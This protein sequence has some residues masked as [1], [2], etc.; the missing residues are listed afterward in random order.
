MCGISGIIS[1][2]KNDVTTS[3]LKAMTDVLAHRGP[4]G[5][6]QWISADSTVGFGH[7]RLTIIDLSNAGKQPMHFQNRYTIVFN[8]A[9]YNYVELREI[10]I[11]KGYVFN[12]QSDT[13]VIMAMYDWK[14]EECLHYFDG[15][16]AFVLHDAAENILF[17][18]RDRFGEKP[19]YYHHKPGKFFVF[20]SE[21][22]ALWAAGIKKEINNRLLYN[23][24]A[25]NYIQNDNDLSE[26]FFQ[27]IRNL[28]PAHYLQLSTSTLE[29]SE[30]KYWD[31][32][33]RKISSDITIDEAKERFRQLFYKSVN[34]R[35]RCDV[36]VGSSLS[37]GIDSST[38][39]AVIN[40]INKSK[41]LCTFSAI[42]PGFEKDE[43]RFIQK[44]LEKIK[45]EAHYTSPDGDTL[46]KNTDECFYYQE[47]PFGSASVIAQY[48]VMKLAK[49]HNVT[50]L[51][52]GQGADEALAGYHHFYDTYF[53]ELKT[54]DRKIY[55]LEKAAYNSMFKGNKINPLPEKDLRYYAGRWGWPGKDRLK[56]IR[57]RINQVINPYFNPDFYYAYKNEQFHSPM[58]ATS[59]NQAL[60][61]SIKFGLPQL[62]RFADRN[63]M[64]NGREIRLPFLF[65]ELVELIFTL[66]P[67][68]KIHNGWTKYI[69][70][71][72]F[73]ELLPTSIT[74]R[75]DKIGYEPPQ[76]QWMENK[77]LKDK[78][79]NTREQLVK[80]R[81]LNSRV[82]KKP[83]DGSEANI[84]KKNGWNQLMISCLLSDKM[85][86]HPN[87][88][89]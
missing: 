81:I 38:I 46:L 40:D 33:H 57:E 70:R 89:K 11:N 27:H 39:V 24:M 14:K 26:T 76:R 73:E 17:I 16:F 48:G 82:L 49:Q 2:D 3:R 6:G 83:I 54:R 78:I 51:L 53:T 13:E 23:Y 29:C 20:A 42:F 5:D 60:Y 44:L 21:M 9:I 47:E 35:L 84:G 52:D 41:K 58:P 28:P 77:T 12:S 56:K 30:K 43:S 74:W 71:I 69:E 86:F 63:S 45:V 19:L 34:R 37:G 80:D 72:S 7:R 66:P 31:I 61:N 22:K 36:S 87:Q 25:F 18:A 65:H 50:V 8:G 4:D 62:L 68:F 55:K 1:V 88:A 32:D 59:L 67:A 85:N 75:K 79:L 15:M 64:S 10:C